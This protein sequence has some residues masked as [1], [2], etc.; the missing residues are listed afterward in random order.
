MRRAYAGLALACYTG[1]VQPLVGTPCANHPDTPA[2]A[3]CG[4]CA[5]TVCNSCVVFDLAGAATCS[6]CAGAF[7]AGTGSIP[8]ERRAELGTMTAFAR[9]VKVVLLSP[10]EALAPPASPVGVGAPLTFA[11][12]GQTLGTIFTVFWQVAMSLVM[13]RGGMGVGL[14]E[15]GVIGGLGVLSGP[16]L[17]LYW[18]FVWGGVVHLLLMMFGG[19]RGGFTATARVQ[20]YASA[21]ALLNAVPMVGGMIGVVWS[22]VI[23]IVGLASAH[24]A[25]YGKSAAAV[26]APLVL[27]CMAAAAM[28]GMAAWGFSEMLPN[29]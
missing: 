26:L 28:V 7:G 15:L 3:T 10:H 12:L 25:G 19:A 14:P 1:T 13:S 29:Q 27:C 23:Q 24:E 16:I 5:R 21:A 18:V 20:G 8:W 6:T 9:T 2:S 11:L 22:V 17:A 4:R